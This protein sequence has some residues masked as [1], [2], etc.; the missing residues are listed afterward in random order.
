MNT[1]LTNKRGAVVKKRLAELISLSGE[2]KVL[3]GFFYFSGI[4]ALY[5][6]LVANPKIRLRVLVGMETERVM[7]RQDP[8]LS[9][10]MVMTGCKL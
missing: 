3:V 2:L 1:L 4:K 5:E 6:A 8:F 7:G 9:E 10:V